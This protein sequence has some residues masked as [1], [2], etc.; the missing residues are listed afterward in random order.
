MKHTDTTLDTDRL[1]HDPKMPKGDILLELFS[2]ITSMSD[3]LH[4]PDGLLQTTLRAHK[5]E[6]VTN[7]NQQ[8]SILRDILNEVLEIKHRLGAV[9]D[10]V[11]NH[12]ARL[13]LESYPEIQ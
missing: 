6:T 1:P 4:D 8:I 10:A 5:Q 3:A 11:E 9:E 2:R 7:H 12:E 13:T